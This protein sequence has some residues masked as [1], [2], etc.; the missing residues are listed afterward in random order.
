MFRNCLAATL[1]YIDRN[2][3]YCAIGIASLAVGMCTAL[4]SVLVIHNQYTYDH[5][6]PDY[7]R[8]Y[9]LQLAV[10]PPGLARQYVKYTAPQ[11]GAQLKLRLPEVEATTRVLE[12]ASRVRHGSQLSRET[13]Y[14]ADS[15][16]QDVLHFTGIA[17]DF[18]A[19][20]HTPDSVA[21]SRS[22]ARR[23]F[24]RDAPLNEVLLVDG[25]PMIVRAIFQDQPHVTHQERDIIASGISSDSPNSTVGRNAI[26]PLGSLNFVQGMTYLRLRASSDVAVVTKTL[27]AL[28]QQTRASNGPF[29]VLPELIRIDHFNTHPGLHPEFRGRMLLLAILGGVVLLVAAA[30]FVNLQTSRST[31][32]A[33]EAAIRTVAGAPRSLLVMQFL[34]ESILQAGAAALLALALTEWLLPRVDAFLDVGAVTDQLQ[35]WLAPGMLGATL[36]LGL[37]AGAWPAFIQ[38]GFQPVTVL[39]GAAGIPGGTV[40]RQLL[41]TLQ[42][43][44][45]IALAICAG[46]VDRQ[47]GF[48]MHE[49]LRLDTDQVLM[50]HVPHPL[51]H[52]NA[53]LDRIQALPGVKAGIW[54]SVPLLG[55]TGFRGLRARQITLARGQ[56]GGQAFLDVV[57]ADFRLFDFFG[58]RPLAGHVPG[59]EDRSTPVTDPTS[60]VLNETAAR[61][62]GLRPAQAIGRS[63]SLPPLGKPEA[64]GAM[65][66]SRIL[67]VVPDVS[68]NTVAAAVPATVYIQPRDGTGLDFKKLDLLAVRL[69]GRDI[70]ETLAAIDALWRR[71][72]SV[73][74][75]ERFFLDEHIQ[76]L[77]QGV[78]RQSQ[79]FGICAL[80]A[81]ALSCI[82]LSALAAAMAE[83]RRK[84]IGIRKALGAHTGDVLKL[85]LWQ[86]SRPVVWANLLAWPSAAFVMHRWLSGFAYHV[87][88]PIW[89]FPASAIAALL[90]T[91]ATVGVQSILVARENPVAPLRHE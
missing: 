45:L 41:T 39:N 37:L 2:R 38:S 58:I 65:V 52:P 11:A 69:R 60:V 76:L 53:F 55:N 1:R 91:V 17:G 4:V 50:I 28:L 43:A 67:A 15:N 64:V 47:R 23:F 63:V 5:T 8:T 35:P 83:Q 84:E 42:F 13:V 82:G 27:Q 54:A 40:V 21:L 75:M 62:L 26:D 48:A 56:P 6:L 86:F 18:D 20:L 66:D 30:N 19:S 24:G 14:W 9:I 59:P 87:E 88:L 46:V 73:D 70:P 16:V 12:T 31:Q 49:A 81:M 78:L 32:R 33:R 90:I 80:L 44:L 71:S 85:L 3:I 34:G 57:D 68:L 72:G 22:A 74:P 51:A 77:Y 61:K 25:H 36:L 10:M 29:T 79:A 7:K 89:M